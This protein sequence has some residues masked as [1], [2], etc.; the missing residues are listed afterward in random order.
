MKPYFLILLALFTLSVGYGA[1]V[2]LGVNMRIKAVNG[3][4]H[5]ATDIVLVRGT[6]NSWNISDTLLDLDNDSIYTKTIS[7]PAP[8]TQ[9]FKFFYFDSAK[10]SHW[11]NDPNRYIN[12]FASGGTF[13]YYFNNDTTL[14]KSITIHF[15]CDMKIERL[16]GDFQPNVEAVSVNGDF[17][18]WVAMTNIMTPNESNTDLYET[19]VIISASVGTSINYKFWYQPDVWESGENRTYTINQT[20]FDNG[21]TTLQRPFNDLTIDNML[22]YPCRITFTVQTTGAIS[23]LTGQ[24]F[25]SVNTVYLAGNTSPLQWPGGGW[26]NADITKM[27]QLYDDGTHGD[28]T[29]GDHIFSA[30][31]IFP[32]YTQLV[33][34]YRYSCNYGND[35]LNNGGND[36]ESAWSE[37]H[38]LT[39][40]SSMISATTLD[41][42]GV[43]LPSTLIDIVV[44]SAARMYVTPLSDFASVGAIGGPF[45]PE[46]K[47]YTV[48]NTGLNPLSWSVTTT[49]PWITVT[50]SAGSLEW[51]NSTSVT[52]SLTDAVNTLM[53][54]V[55]TDT[56]YFKNITNGEGD[57]FQLV[58]L[59]VQK[60]GIPLLVYDNDNHQDT[61]HFGFY[62]NASTCID[63]GL[64]EIELP[65]LPPGNTF[66]VRLINPTP[67]IT[68]FGNGL[69]SDLRPAVPPVQIDTFRIAFSSPSYPITISWD[70]SLLV[71]LYSVNVSLMDTGWGSSINVDMRRTSTIQITDTSVHE[72]LLVTGY[73]VIS[74]SG[75]VFGDIN[76]DGI[77]NADDQPMS[78]WRLYLNGSR[79]DS[80]ITD[81]GGSYCFRNLIVGTYTVSEEER[82]LLYHVQ[83]TGNSLSVSTIDSPAVMGINF[84]NAYQIKWNLK[85]RWNMVSLPLYTSADSVHHV[86]NTAT[87][88]AFSYQGSYSQA[89]ELQTGWGYWLKFSGTQEIAPIGLL[90]TEDTI[91]VTPGWNLIGSLSFPIAVSSITSE[92]GG[93]VTSQFYKFNDC[94]TTIDTI[95][96]GMGSWVK[97]DQSGR[98]I[99]SSTTGFRSATSRIT[100]IATDEMPPPSPEVQTINLKPEKF[101]LSQNFPNPFNP[102]TVINYQISADTWT[103]LK[104]YNMLGAEVATLVNEMQEA[105]Y[106]SV[107]FNAQS[108][109]SGVYF[110][111]L[112]AGTFAAEKKLMIIK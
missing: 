37:S 40:S 110:Y 38:T 56:L 48:K 61:L 94:Y 62:T 35:A 89:T 98:L 45:H 74:I 83:P 112:S 1:D 24:P 22:R 81:T 30:E 79:T 41:D 91:D 51:G 99:L 27:I 58:T 105:G 21:Y 87:S 85:D 82:P 49:Q 102:S 107:T 100:I 70:Q 90:L 80:T 47:S 26:P 109:P 23:A 9:Y 36:N 46:S 32:A 7:L 13:I 11:E 43:L 68:C 39:M 25:T 6:F 93:I 75:T 73:P 15:A 108:L 14:I 104:V 64:A 10:V 106:K 17:N 72:L 28:A 103:I 65:P 63:P 18:G 97:V 3:E 69:H 4:F 5:P 8:T 52:V 31:V 16:R 92:P 86:F 55:Y 78:G 76:H 111:R 42:F 71:T 60:P 34:D 96:P 84:A 53:D 19:D 2:T 77:F 50:P 44:D 12:V 54:G 88:Q 59:T 66:D 20:D 57:S 33:V 101:S 29:I 95:S 67:S